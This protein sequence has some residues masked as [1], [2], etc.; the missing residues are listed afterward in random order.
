MYI[1]AYLAILSMI[2]FSFIE[3]MPGKIP[4]CILQALI[5][6]LTDV[7]EEGDNR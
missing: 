1:Q 4:P 2:V 5:A 7:A 3:F 6:S